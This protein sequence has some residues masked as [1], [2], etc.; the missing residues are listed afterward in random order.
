MLRYYL[1]YD[2]DEDLARG[3]LILFL[4]FRD[5]MTEIHQK[6]VT[7]L[8][9]SKKDLINPKRS[10][11]EKYQVM[12]DLINLIHKESEKNSL[13]SE[14]EDLIDEE[15]TSPEDIEDFTKWAKSQAL[16]ELSKFKSLT[17]LADIDSLRQQISQLN[18]QQRKL[19][20]DISERMISTDINEPPV[21]LFIAGEAGTGKSHLVRL[22]IEAVK[23]LKIK[24]GDEIK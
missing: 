5:E 1:A 18:C 10:R 19:F 15:T 20:D 11:F 16:K 12:N 22:L 14:A 7:E 6:D 8:L 4:P 3:L 21:Y 17:E 24:A 23:I 13:E 9:D 2:N